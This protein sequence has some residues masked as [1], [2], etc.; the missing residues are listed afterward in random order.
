MYFYFYI[1]IN[2]IL[3]DSLWD[4]TTP[5]ANRFLIEGNKATLKAINNHIEWAQITTKHFINQAKSKTF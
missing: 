3:E 4:L 2:T 5:Y 1:V